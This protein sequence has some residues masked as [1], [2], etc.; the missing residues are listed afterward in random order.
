MWKS[1][2]CTYAYAC[3]IIIHKNI[4]ISK[5]MRNEHLITCIRR[6]VSWRYPLL[7]KEYFLNK[8]KEKKKNNT[9]TKFIYS[10]AQVSKFNL[11]ARRTQGQLNKFYWVSSAEWFR[12]KK[13]CICV[14]VC[15]Y[16]CNVLFDLFV[17]NKSRICVMLSHEPLLT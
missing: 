5:N 3:F 15:V 9:L 2:K 17:L 16:M 8:E 12:L 11:K 14:C 4:T 6:C 7:T 13:R 1:N 10:A